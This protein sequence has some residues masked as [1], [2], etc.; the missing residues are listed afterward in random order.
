MSTPLPPTP[1][2]I[3]IEI[4]SNTPVEWWSSFVTPAGALLG[5]AIGGA[6]A[7][8]S[9]RSSDER[10]RLADDR[11]QWD[12]K[13]LD[14]HVSLALAAKPFYA[15]R[16]HN[17]GD[18][19]HIAPLVPALEASIDVMETQLTIVKMIA[20]DCES[21]VQALVNAATASKNDASNGT[22]LV[23]T[24]YSAFETAEKTV[25][26]SFQKRARIERQ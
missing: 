20:P 8:I 6:I 10:K 4:I 3:P 18:T 21:A 14:V 16:E 17:I 11:R 19:R 9:V 26:E 23:G 7:F 1:S 24:S 22:P 5:A 2:P 15:T 12:S 25:L 13:L